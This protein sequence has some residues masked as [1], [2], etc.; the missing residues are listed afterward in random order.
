MNVFIERVFID[1]VR[2]KLMI[3]L[4]SKDSKIIFLK[5]LRRSFDDAL[6]SYFYLHMTC[7]LHKS[8]NFVWVA[9]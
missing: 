7:F 3:F 1:A 2:V 8:A 6:S 4:M 9:I 5:K